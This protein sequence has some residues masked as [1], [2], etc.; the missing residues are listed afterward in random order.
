MCTAGQLATYNAFNIKMGT[1]SLSVYGPRQKGN[2][3]AW[4]LREK[5]KQKTPSALFC[6]SLFLFFGF[7]SYIY[8]RSLPV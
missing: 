6:V 3:R 4:T 7:S 2:I 5:K 8:V 1:A